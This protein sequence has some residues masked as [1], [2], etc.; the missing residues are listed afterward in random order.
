MYKI[1]FKDIHNHLVT[2]YFTHSLTV[3]T[4][5]DGDSR[6]VDGNNGEWVI[7]KVYHTYKQIIEIIDEVISGVK[8]NWKDE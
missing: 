7:P 6:I 4:T 5:V 1:Q 3:Y 2:I 8:Y